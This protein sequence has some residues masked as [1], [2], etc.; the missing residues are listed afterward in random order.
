MNETMFRNKYAT[1]YID[2]EPNKEYEYQSITDK[3]EIK[4]ICDKYINEYFDI[5]DDKETWFN[6]LKE[7]SSVLGY[8]SE[9]KE[10]KENPDNYKGHVGDIA[11]VLRVTLTT[12]SNTPD[13]YEIMKLLGKERIKNRFN[14][15]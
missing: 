7:L 5:N 6:K 15:I 13:L 3:Q 8:A 10:Y 1:Y 11:T 4:I 14:L 9:V 2:I 12:K